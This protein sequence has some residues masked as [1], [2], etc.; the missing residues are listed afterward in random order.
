M[1]TRNAA[2]NDARRKEILAAASQC[3]VGLGFH[4]TS[5]QDVCRA[6]GM[7]AGNLYHYFGSKAD[8]IAGII[9]DERA[10]MEDLFAIVALSE[11]F[12]EGLFQALDVMA[13]EVT[14]DDLTLH[15]EVAAELLR[16]PVLRAEA[17]ANDA[18]SR[19]R[20]AAALV[21]AQEKGSVDRRLDPNETAL[22]VTSLLDGLMWHATLQGTAGLVSRL[23]FVKQALARMLAD[24]DACAG[25][26]R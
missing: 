7:S 19:N 11:D 20:L 17:Q 1:R 26:A 24:P 4:A 3:F 10:L 22:L 9:A 16:D 2:L 18:A 13:N 15:A 6:A 8:L 25:L 12:I 14:D 21:K 5:M 23:P